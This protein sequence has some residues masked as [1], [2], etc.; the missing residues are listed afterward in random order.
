MLICL[1]YAVSDELHQTFV[2]GRSGEV[3][4]VCFDLCGAL[5]AYLVVRL[6]LFLYRKH[7]SGKS[8]SLSEKETV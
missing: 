4:D 8:G 1:A 2:D 3:R 7:Q 6:I 5:I